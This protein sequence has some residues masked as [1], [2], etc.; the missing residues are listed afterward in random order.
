MKQVFVIVPSFVPDGPMKGAVALCNGMAGHCAVRIVSI[1]E[2]VRSVEGE[3]SSGMDIV[4]LE[5]CGSWTRKVKE[6]KKLVRDAAR[7]GNVTLISFSLKSDIMS[8]A[9]REKVKRICSVRGNLLINYRFDYGW[10]GAGAAIA[11]YQIMRLFDVVV[12][13]SDSMTNQLRKYGV[14]RIKK[15][16]N[17]ID[18]ENLKKKDT[19]VFSDHEEVKFVFLG[20]LTERKRPALVVDAVINSN[21]MGGRC[22]LDAVGD[23]PLKGE[24]EELIRKSSAES[25]VKMHGYMENPHTA[26][27]GCD[28]MVL[29]SESEGVSRAVMEALYFGVSCII[30][31]VDG[32]RELVRDGENGYLFQNDSEF[33]E[34][35]RQVAEEGPNRNKDLKSLLPDEFRQG[36]CVNEYMELLR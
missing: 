17:F 18:E 19:K 2:S 1:S 36:R 16:G 32:N 12:T 27:E 31:D 23:G 10:K 29:P 22:T 25:I 4:K 5:S 21:A 14:K 34:L 11:H 24:I 20:S 33:I 13:M 28:Y 26:F 9:V 6:L 35:V 15:I 3:I 8:L 30:R 7:F